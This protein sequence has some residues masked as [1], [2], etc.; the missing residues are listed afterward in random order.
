MRRR[1]APAAGRRRIPAFSSAEKSAGRDIA[2]ATATCYSIREAG[3]LQEHGSAWIN[4]SDL[5][6]GLTGR[7]GTSK[8]AGRDAADGVFEVIVE[9]LTSGDEVRIQGLGKFVI[10]NRAARAGRN[11]GRGAQVENAVSS[12]P[13]DRNA[14]TSCGRITESGLARD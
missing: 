10:G 2:P 4:R 14:I 1:P 11:P 3:R 8:T 13:A 7:T 12:T 5:A 9:T 6:E